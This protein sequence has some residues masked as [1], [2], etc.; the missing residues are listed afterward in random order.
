MFILSSILNIYNGYSRRG[1]KTS[2]GIACGKETSRIGN[3]IRDSKTRSSGSRELSRLG[4]NN[5]SICCQSRQRT[6]YL[7]SFARIRIT[8]SLIPL[9]FLYNSHLWT[10]LFIIDMSFSDELINI[11]IIQLNTIVQNIQRFNNIGVI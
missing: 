11:N 8:L 3:S 4:E 2:K 10:L 5:V 7:E 6:F 9:Y 1:R